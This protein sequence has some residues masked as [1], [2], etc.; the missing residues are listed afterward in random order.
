ML[1]QKGWSV[2]DLTCIYSGPASPLLIFTIRNNQ[3]PITLVLLCV[4]D[5]ALTK[6]FCDCFAIF[7]MSLMTDR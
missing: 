2:E 5:L 1:K 7:P 3:I 6:G 4:Y